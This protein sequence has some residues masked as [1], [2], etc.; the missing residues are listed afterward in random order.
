VLSLR[1]EY[2]Y[3]AKQHHTIFN[4][5]FAEQKG[6]SIGNL[7]AIWRLPDSLVP[8]LT[9]QAFVENIGDVDYVTNHAPNATTGSTLS[10]FGP[11]RTWGVQISYAWAAE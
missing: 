5:D 6:F 11:P 2:A 8:G 7:R 9:F 3:T 1:G 10:T 4:N